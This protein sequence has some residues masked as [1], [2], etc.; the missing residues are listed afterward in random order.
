[1]ES[2][3]DEFA[4]WF[5]PGGKQDD[6][7]SS[8]ADTFADYLTGMR[9]F[10]AYTD[11]LVVKAVAKHRKVDIQVYKFND[12]KGIFVNVFS[13]VPAGKGQDGQDVCVDQDVTTELLE[14]P[15][16]LLRI[17]H[18]SH[19]TEMATTI[20]SSRR[21]YASVAVSYTHLTLPTIY[22]V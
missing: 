15:T 9:E 11:N 5:E 4:P 19:R 6:L 8:S 22:S 3:Q 1:M 10:S 17:M 16:T 14:K 13:G 20:A 7:H 2:H 12:T 21:R 18:T